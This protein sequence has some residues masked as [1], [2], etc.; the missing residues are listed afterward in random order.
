MPTLS[1][2]GSLSDRAWSHSEFVPSETADS[3]SS[4]LSQ[5]EADQAEPEAEPIDTVAALSLR[6]QTLHLGEGISSSSQSA[7]PL[8]AAGSPPAATLEASPSTEAFRF[9]CVWRLPGNQEFRGIHSGPG[10]AA[11][12]RLL[13]LLPGGRYE[14]SSGVRFR[15]CNREEAE[16]TYRAEAPRHGA[17]LPPRHFVWN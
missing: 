6:A 10:L 8:Q 9:Y 5:L 13:G 3:F 15:R 7:H 4:L 12:N 17:P 16:D 1:E 14:Y 11:F 2:I